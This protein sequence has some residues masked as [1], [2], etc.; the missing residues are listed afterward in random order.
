MSCSVLGGVNAVM[1]YIGRVVLYYNPF[2]FVAF[3]IQI[4]TLHTTSFVEASS[5]IPTNLSPPPPPP[6]P[7]LPLHDQHK[8]SLTPNSAP[9][10][11]LRLL[12]SR[13]L[14]RR[15]QRNPL[16]RHHRLQPVPLAHPSAAL[17]LLLPPLRLRIAG[18]SGRRRCPLG[19][20][21]GC[22]PGGRRSRPSRPSLASFHYGGFLWPVRRLSHPL[23]P[24]PRRARRAG[25]YAR[26]LVL[27]LHG[28]RCAAD[29]CP[30]RV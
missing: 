14:L 4:S 30:L 11:R 16:L 26:A 15:H 3:M 7:L 5:Y 21:R 27:R 19:R 28:G 25:G 29:S 1:G 17:L 8:A 20:V 23:R 10:Q 24:V 12:R 18:A 9:S 6:P 22:E 13:L 2:N